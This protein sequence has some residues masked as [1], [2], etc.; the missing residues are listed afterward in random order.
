MRGLQ[1]RFILSLNDHQEVRE[2]YAGFHMEEVRTTYR[3]AAKRAVERGEL[4]IWVRLGRLSD[5]G[6]NRLC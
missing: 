6:A 1:G 4:V 3:V 5:V 2:S